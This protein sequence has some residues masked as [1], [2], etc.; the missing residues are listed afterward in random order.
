MIKGK[1]IKKAIF[2]LSAFLLS[3][4]LLFADDI[5][6][7]ASVNKTSLPLNDSLIY[8][9]T[10]SGNISNFPEPQIKLSDFN[11]YGTGRS[12]SMS[13]IN[14]KVS[15]SVVF[16][17]TIVPKA[18]GKWTIA[19]ASIKYKNQTYT[20]EPITVEVTAAQS[21]QRQTAPQSSNQNQQPQR[22]AQ[23]Q[24]GGKIFVESS[25][26][27][28]TVYENEKVVYRFSFYTNMDLASNPEYYPPDFGGF[29]N[30]GSQPKNRQ[31]VIDGVRYNVSELETV[32]Y[33]ISTGDK[34]IS[35]S[36]LRVAVRDFS[37]P[38]N[39]DKFIAQFFANAGQTQVKDLE[40]KN[41]K[42]KVLP[43]PQEGRPNN[44]FGAVGEFKI[45]AFVDK[46]QVNTNDPVTLTVEVS[47]DANMKSVVKLDF[48]VENSLR[49]YDT[50]VSKATADSKVFS[51]ILIPLTPGEK[52]IP[53]IEL[54]FFNPKT[55]KYET[56]RTQTIKFIASGEPVQEEDVYKSGQSGAIGKDINYNKQI[57]DIK[58]YAG[59]Y[60]E[61]KKFFI[62]FIP[63]ILLLIGA[64]MFKNLTK[65][66]QSI[67]FKSKGAKF[68]Q[69]WRFIERAEYEIEHGNIG[70]LYDLIYNALIE[71]V[72]AAS[73]LKTQNLQNSQILD[74][75]NSK[76]IP[77]SIVEKVKKV[78]DKLNLY[79]FAAVRADE[80]SLKEM[81]NGVKEIISELKQ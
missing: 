33:P 30:D 56:V 67:S 59:N 53:Q 17:Y 31:T 71:A 26:N 55:K 51:T 80:K 48:A 4:A 3:A 7:S 70:G 39:V 46:T 32:L 2:F 74:F 76:E 15:G 65:K 69:A 60:I 57:S 13:V 25:I 66:L 12:Q 54:S 64:F 34:N 21:V 40:T 62:I 61:N 58:T 52:T 45:K 81:L 44:F 5:T 18:I 37:M 14:G 75:L 50:I 28:K 11:V 10:I 79:K 35:P 42:I 27:K 78:L 16:N 29:W 19:P 8:S 72:C 49:K 1:T 22:A 38:D 20:T 47:G 24:N 23:S 41:L 73:G 43:L 77:Q 9:V 6:I 36:R 68:N 63:F